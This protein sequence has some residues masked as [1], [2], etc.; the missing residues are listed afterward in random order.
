MSMLVKQTSFVSFWYVLFYVRT[1]K[2]C[3]LAAVAWCEVRPYQGYVQKQKK[4][5]PEVDRSSGRCRLEAF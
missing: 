5:P 2:S 1:N 4:E 3:L